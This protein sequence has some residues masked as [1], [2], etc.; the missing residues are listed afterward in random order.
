MNKIVLLAKIRGKN[1]RQKSEAN[2][3]LFCTFYAQNTHIHIISVSNAMS[4]LVF[5]EPGVRLNVS[6]HLA[7]EKSVQL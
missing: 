7:S 4:M 6:T 1:Q 2:E 3:P 5:S